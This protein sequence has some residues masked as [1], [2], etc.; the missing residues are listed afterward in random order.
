[1]CHVLSDTR[2]LEKREK[3]KRHNNEVWKWFMQINSTGGICA[4]QKKKKKKMVK[5]SRGKQR[6]CIGIGCAKTAWKYEIDFFF[7]ASVV[8]A[9]SNRI[10]E[11]N[12]RTWE[13]NLLCSNEFFYCV[14]LLEKRAKGEK[15]SVWMTNARCSCSTC[16]ELIGAHKSIEHVQSKWSSDLA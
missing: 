5:S 16:S 10:N 13:G 11:I 12:G 8:M 4:E 9:C 2:K 15:K 14:C 3:K 6:N 7:S 1:M